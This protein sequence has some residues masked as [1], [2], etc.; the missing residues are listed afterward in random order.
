M[1]VRVAHVLNSPGNGGVPRVAL[2]LVRHLDPTKI[3]NHVFYLKPG[4]G[5]DLF[6]DDRIPVRHAGSDSKAD[7]MA[8]L[9]AWLERHRIDIL[10]THSFRPNLYARMAGAVLRPA[11]LRI[12]AHYHNDYSD[13]WH[14]AALALERS[15]GDV[16]DAAL[17]VSAPVATH[18][19]TLT[20]SRPEVLANGVDLDRVTGGDRTAGRIALGLP[21]RALV[22]GLVGR[23]CRQKG[24]DTF[25]EAAFQLC[26][27]LPQARFIVI[28]DHEDKALASKLSGRI[29][30]SDWANRILLAGHRRDMA[31]CFAA[32]DV[33]VAPSRWEGF[34][35]AL[36]EAMA[37]GVPLIATDVGGIPEVVGSA[38]RLIAPDD[39]DTLAAEIETMTGQGF[40]R[41]PLIAAGK[42]RARRFDWSIAGDRLA[43]LYARLGPRP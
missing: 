2:A 9:V 42:A 7:A 19:A 33:L 16:T 30:A 1:T 10:H 18:V 28:G 15:L 24:V 37:A 32:M 8:D 11:G 6:D 27:R 5:D 14:G 29:A 41:D 34:G 25:V 3:A 13:K 17:A 31:D 21:D 35:L 12:V 4:A 26:P 36:A 40:D 38:G 39:P 23:I 20:G 43:E 22:V